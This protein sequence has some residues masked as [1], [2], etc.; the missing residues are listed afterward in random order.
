M[1]LL[2]GVSAEGTAAQRVDCAL[3]CGYKRILAADPVAEKQIYPVMGGD[4]RRFQVDDMLSVIAENACGTG[5][6][7]NRIVNGFF[8]RGGEGTL[9]R[10]GQVEDFI[11]VDEKVRAFAVQLGDNR[12]VVHYCKRYRAWAKEDGRC[13]KRGCVWRQDIRRRYSPRSGR[14]RIL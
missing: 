12:G 11:A 3:G 9:S 13:R 8:R 5:I 14:T 6:K 7:L 4:L 2:V 10:F 1:T